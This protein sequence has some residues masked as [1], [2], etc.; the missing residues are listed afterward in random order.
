M[1]FERPPERVFHAEAPRRV[2][3][4]LGQ[5]LSDRASASDL[6]KMEVEFREALFFGARWQEASNTQPY[7]N[8]VDAGVRNGETGV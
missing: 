1:T 8:G 5:A 4:K 3:T 6:P 2:N 7:L